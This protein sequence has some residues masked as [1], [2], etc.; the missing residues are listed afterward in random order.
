MNK[1]LQKNAMEVL[2]QNSPHFWGLNYP[3]FRVL[4]QEFKIPNE[5]GT[6]LNIKGISA[7]LP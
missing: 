3:D 6:Q 7:R 1:F 2:N 4:L 5:F